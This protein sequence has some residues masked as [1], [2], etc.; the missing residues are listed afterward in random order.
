M[1]KAKEIIKI[2]YNTLDDKKGEDIKIL[3]IHEVSTIADYFIIASGRNSNQVQAMADAVEEKLI[4][5]GFEMLNKEGY[6]SAGWILLDFGSVVIHVFDKEVRE[7]Y[8][9]ERLWGDAP[10]ITPQNL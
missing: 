2:A 7:F 6:H 3:D 9:L 8:C 1:E 10:T 5:H 4:E